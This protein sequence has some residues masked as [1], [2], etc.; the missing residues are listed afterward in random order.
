MIREE[1]VSVGH[2][3][4]AVLNIAFPTPA[5][6]RASPS[7]LLDSPPRPVPRS[8][9][10]FHPQNRRW[11]ANVSERAF[12]FLPILFLL[13]HFEDKSEFYTPRCICINASIFLQDQVVIRV[14]FR[15]RNG[16]CIALIL[17]AAPVR[18]RSFRLVQA[19][20]AFS[21]TYT[22]PDC[23]PIVSGSSLSRT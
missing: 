18:D 2:A 12:I 14:T 21:R 3:H 6:C 7:T 19:Y 5:D 13:V 10:R 8:K 16:F 17:K 4:A 22:Y 15:F 1:K 20:F 9:R 11:P 23:G